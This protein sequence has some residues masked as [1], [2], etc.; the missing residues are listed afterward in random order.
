MPPADPFIISVVATMVWVSTSW[1]LEY[2]VTSWEWANAH[3]RGELVL[4]LTAF[5][6]LLVL[7]SWSYYKTVVTHPGRVPV[8]WREKAD[9]LVDERFPLN[10]VHGQRRFCTFCDHWKPPRTHH[11]S[12]CKRCILKYDHHCPWV[13]NCIGFYNHKHFVLFITYLPLLCWIITVSSFS[14]ATD[15]FHKI[16]HEL[17]TT[18]VASKQCPLV[19][20][21]LINFVITYS[22]AFLFAVLITWFTL[23]QYRLLLK[24]K[25]VVEENHS[26]DE[27]DEY[28]LGCE[29]N[30]Y[31]TFG[32]NCILWPFPIAPTKVTETEGIF[33]PSR[34]TFD[35]EKTPL[36]GSR[37]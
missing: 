13:G 25:T 22:L 35:T 1:Y 33:Y 8:R 27:N 34:R 12:T 4:L 6:V 2:F 17:P 3:E 9:P 20:F 19:G 15:C 18:R 23:N 21:S 16:T 24:N 37:Y 28:N 36:L 31:A 10:S 11:C 14:F 32:E 7:C 5:G 26:L 29:R 30:F